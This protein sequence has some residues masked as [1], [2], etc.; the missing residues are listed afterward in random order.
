MHKMELFDILLKI[1]WYFNFVLMY[2]LFGLELNIVWFG[3]NW[4]L[5]WNLIE[6][7]LELYDISIWMEYNM[8]WNYLIIGA[9]F[10]DVWFK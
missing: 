9:R 3:I 10:I 5:V 1:N 2:L 8:V 7:G 6:F 4:Y